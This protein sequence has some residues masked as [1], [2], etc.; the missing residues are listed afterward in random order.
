MKKIITLL[1]GSVFVFT[2][3]YTASVYLEIAKNEEIL[4]SD[5]GKTLLAEQEDLSLLL[6]SFERESEHLSQIADLS[7][8]KTKI[9]ETILS[10]IV[11]NPQMNFS[12]GWAGAV[13]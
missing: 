4:Y 11:L 12:S 10:I 1:I 9:S 13:L 8:L 3:Y 5:I 7:T 2:I 6:T